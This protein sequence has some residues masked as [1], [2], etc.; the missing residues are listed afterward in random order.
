[1]QMLRNARWRTAIG[2]SSACV[3]TACG[4]TPTDNPPI[5]I[6]DCFVLGVT[7]TPA[8]VTMHPKDTAVL[9]GSG[10]TDCPAWRVTVQWQ[11]TDST[12]AVVASSTDSTAMLV[13]RAAGSTTVVAR[14]V[15]D[16]VVRGAVS[17]TVVP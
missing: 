16:P 3:V 13:A 9:H 5:V 6:S 2:L 7:V 10:A 15:Q 4:R 14:A 1:M 11:V 17:V 8:T 12:V